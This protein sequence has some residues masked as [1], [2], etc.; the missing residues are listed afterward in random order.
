M[1][2]GLRRLISQHLDESF[3]Y[4]VKRQRRKTIALHVLSDG[5]V[6]VRAPK[7]VSRFELADFVEQRSDWVISQRRVM[8]QK[9]AQRPGFYQGQAHYFLGY[10]Y[11]LQ[12]TPAARGRVVCRDEQLHIA[13]RD[14]HCTESIERLLWQ[15]YRNQAVAIF[16][17]RL[18]A[19]YEMFPEWFQDKYPM[20][21]LKIRKMRRRWGSCTSKGLVTLNLALIKMPID[22][23]DYVVCHE[24]CHLE[25][26][27]HG[28][29][30]Y[31]LL[32]EVMPGWRDHERLIEQ[33]SDRF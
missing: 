9:A 13:T 19:C 3:E 25:V 17:E 21:E 14:V 10:A 32:A 28:R 8:L 11:P 18:F 4:V 29:E 31:G 26:F 12:I 1:K 15:W 27:H 5:S 2:A 6:E 30:F 22:C 20:P 33:F 24:L 23:I 16:E 7:W